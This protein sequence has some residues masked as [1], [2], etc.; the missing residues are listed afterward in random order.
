[1]PTFRQYRQRMLALEPSLGRVEVVASLTTT[2]IV[3]SALAVGSIMA[4]KFT[5]KW[6]L[7][8]N[9]ADV[10][11]LIRQCS[12]FTAASGTLTHAG[13]G[14][15]DTTA[16]SESVEILEHEP[17]RYAQAIQ[18]ALRTTRFLDRTPIPARLDGRYWLD[19]LGWIEQPSDI[20]KV[21]WSANSAITPNRH[22]EKWNGV[23]SAGALVPDFW[24]LAGSGA[25]FP[26][27]T[28]ARRGAYSLNITRSSNDASA[29]LSPGLLVTGVGSDSLA[30]RKVSVIAV[31]QQDA[32][33]QGR[34][35]IDDGVGQT[36]SD[37]SAT[38]GEF[39]ELTAER[40]LADAATKLD[41][42]VRNEVDGAL[43]VDEGALLT[44][45]LADS[46]RRDRMGIAWEDR[47]PVFDQ[48]QTLLLHS[49]AGR[50]A[51]IVIV[52]ERPYHEFDA[53]RVQAGTAEGDN[54]DAPLDLI[55]YGALA[56]I[57][58][59]LA[60]GEGGTKRQAQLAGHYQGLY[61]QRADGH[62]F[63]QEGAVPGLL[64]DV[65]PAT[66]GNVG[67]RVR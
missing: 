18:E 3:V 6:L 21:G 42:I 9:A 52:S 23:S 16:T 43:L 11:D 34:V 36:T 14:Y 60:L 2:T 55:A 29:T 37:V 50:G 32:A 38:T 25:T 8:T 5:Q 1:M 41:L 54:H 33:S 67:A 53:T 56:R 57:F 7:R 62:L 12:A 46:H 27:S 20:R 65:L 35:E 45:A 19:D 64:E 63:A 58:E 30:G 48:G 4:G 13:T 44:T 51:Q 26:R 47:L 40:T 15:I 59:N 61:K 31:V 39:I 66:R 28:T 22:F 10:A 24:T 49:R 17:Y